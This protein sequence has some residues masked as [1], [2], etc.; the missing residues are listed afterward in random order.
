MP[1]LTKKRIIDAATALI[2]REGLSAF[3]MRSLGKE[4]GVSAMAI[5]GYFPS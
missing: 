3:T 5:Y 4:L 1:D 2:E